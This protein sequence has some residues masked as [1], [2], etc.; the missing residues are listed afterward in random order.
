VSEKPADPT[1]VV[2]LARVRG[3][4]KVW[5]ALAKTD[6]GAPLPTLANILIILR[7]DP[8][9]TGIVTLNEFTHDT[10]IVRAPPPPDSDAP[11]LPGPYPRQWTAADESLILAYIQRR[12]IARASDKALQQAM[13]AEAAMRGFH[14]VR[15]W[16]DTLK[17]DGHKRLDTWLI[18]TFGCEDT[19][20]HRDVGAKFLIAAVRRVRQPGCKFDFMPIFEG[21]QGIGKSTAIKTLF[22]AEW[23]SDSISR[24][25]GHKDAAIGL[26]GVWC[27]EMAEI[28]TLIRSEVETIKA[29]LSRSVDKYRDH[30]GRRDVTR[31]RHGVT[32]GTTNDNNYLRD[33]TGNRR[34]WPIMCVKADVAWVAAQRDQLW[35]EA[36]AAEQAGDPI[37]LE[38]PE[39]QKVATQQQADRVWED[40]WHERIVGFV[41]SRVSTTTTEILEDCLHVALKDQD[42]A[43][44]MRV[45]TILRMLGFKGKVVRDGESV[46]RK[47]VRTA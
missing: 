18:S 7:H 16:L 27:V 38:E 24:D 34:F 46:S 26:L 19:Q 40:T 17:W 15:D 29:F 32:C 11:P 31:P 21:D 25:L 13:A 41:G 3:Q 6:N 9:L 45:A 33:S 30:Y 14:P 39:V 4:N 35:A 22:G 23:F 44:Q 8:V 20:Y 1:S 10:A 37:W 28:D 43:L 42:R 47:W 12:W 5:D 36:N 2:D